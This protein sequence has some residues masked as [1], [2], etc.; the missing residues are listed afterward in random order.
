MSASPADRFKEWL[1][2]NVDTTG[3]SVTRG[4]WVESSAVSGKRFLAIVTSAGRS[5]DAG[6]VEY[7]VIRVIVSGIRDG[8]NVSG[9]VSKVE[10]LARDIIMAAVSDG[11]NA[12]I[13]HIRPIGGISGP[14]F[15]E[16]NRP[17]YELNLEL[18]I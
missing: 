5:F 3:F 2:D 11:T 9:E 10:K 15:S 8:R 13:A 16:E 4:A 14:Y 17:I 12:C 7:P 1:D 18:V 6:I